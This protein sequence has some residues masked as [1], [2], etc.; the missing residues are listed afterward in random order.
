MCKLILNQFKY[1]INFINLSVGC[2][3]DDMDDSGCNAKASEKS[4]HVM[5]PY[6]KM[7]TN[8]WS[9]CSKRFVTELFE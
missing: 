3:H 4:Y 6:V 7:S 5:S 2:G 1:K 8:V 9:K